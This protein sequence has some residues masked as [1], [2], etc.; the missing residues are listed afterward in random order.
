MTEETTERSHGL[1]LRVAR[2]LFGGVLAYSAIDNLRDLDG[3]IEYAKANDAPAPEVT[4]PTA[5]GSLLAGSIGIA[6]WRRPKLAAL[7]V[8]TFL[9]GVTPVMHDFWAVDEEQKEMELIQFTKNLGL[10]GGALAFLNLAE[11][12][13]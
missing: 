1:S 7:A 11:R 10:I 8:L 9:V 4:V 3:M 5:S 2:L 6:F 13:R 12:E